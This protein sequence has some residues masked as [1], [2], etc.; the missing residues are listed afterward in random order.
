[1]D[2]SLITLH[3][4]GQID[5]FQS[6][7]ESIGQT[8]NLPSSIWGLD[9][10]GKN[11]HIKAAVGLPA[12]YVENAVL[13]L[14][15]TNVIGEAFLTG[16]VTTVR[17][18]VADERWKYKNMSLLMGWKSALCVPIKIQDAVVGVI[19]IYTFVEQDFSD[20]EKLL[21][22]IYSDQIRLT[23]EAERRR[24][25][26]R[27]LLEIGENFDRLLTGQPQFV[28][29]E[30]V[31]GACEVISADCAVIY[32]YDPTREEFYD[33]S[34]VAYYGLLKPF[35]LKD[36]LRNAGLGAYIVQQG[37]VICSD[38]DREATKLWKSAFIHREAIKAYMGIALKV[39]DRTLGILFVNFRTPHPFSLEEQDTVRLFANQA[40]LAINNARLYQEARSE[41]IAAKQLAVLGTAMAALQHRINNTFNIIVPNVTRLRNRASVASDPTNLEILDIIERN[42]RYTSEII[43]RIQ[44]PLNAGEPQEVDINAVLTEVTQR[45]RT[46]WEAL[47]N[48]PHVEV[49]LD[50]DDRAPLIRAQIGQIAEVF[51]NLIDNAFRAMKHHRG[52]HLYVTSALRDS[53]VHICVK[54]TGPGVPPQVQERL[55]TKPVPSKEPGGGSGLGLWLS[56]LL[57]QTIGGSVRIDSSYKDGAMILI[58][59]PVEQ[60]REKVAMKARI[61]IIDDEPRWINFARNALN[62]FEV[63]VAADIEKA[64]AELEAG[65]FD[66]VIASS[67][68]LEIL[69]IIRQKFPDKRVV[70]TTVQP[71]TQEALAAYR[72]GAIRYFPKSFSSQDLLSQITD[73]VNV[74][75]GT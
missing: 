64:V 15:E 46:N 5:I 19:S 49:H 31:K 54:D 56:G 27:R 23:F 21:L 22:L 20:K 61:L 26:L 6:I 44:E 24:L 14:D 67:L 53:S 36:K 58:E 63:V 65:Q 45:I 74:P 39:A 38:I 8:M 33:L 3:D 42:A 35:N 60:R 30:I 17:N 1:M 55:F 28:L 47:P 7:V 18:V 13:S 41:V 73:I 70:V 69:E 50:L 62:T 75:A 51:N 4:A 12:D 43:R 29:Q 72:M 52:G 59:I 34:S 25:T 32:P 71:T 11:L 37:E 9:E 16:K 10:E 57:L 48:L 40:A 2:N 68:R 66:L